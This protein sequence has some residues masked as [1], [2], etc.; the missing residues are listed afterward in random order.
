MVRFFRAIVH[1]GQ[2]EAFEE[3]FVEEIL[4]LILAQ[5]GLVSASIDGWP[6][7]QPPGRLRQNGSKDDRPAA[8]LNRTGEPIPEL[9]IRCSA[10]AEARGSKGILIGS[11]KRRFRVDIQFCGGRAV[12]LS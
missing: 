4:P 10:R 5:E 12:V 8:G 7:P 11:R 9:R 2:A 6:D 3:L 1:D